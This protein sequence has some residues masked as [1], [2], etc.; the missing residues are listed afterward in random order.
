MCLQ[1]LIQF[2]FR[3]RTPFLVRRVRRLCVKFLAQWPRT[4]SFIYR[5]VYRAFFRYKY[6]VTFMTMTS[7]TSAARFLLRPTV[8]LVDRDYQFTSLLQQQNYGFFK[9]TRIVI[10][11][12]SMGSSADFYIFDFLELLLAYQSIYEAHSAYFN[13]FCQALPP[14]FVHLF[15]SCFKALVT[16]LI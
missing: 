14:I 2:R 11:A 5:M 13:A 7:S 10:Q 12:F 8:S 9:I 16:P 1:V 6:D 15:R 4:A 3:R